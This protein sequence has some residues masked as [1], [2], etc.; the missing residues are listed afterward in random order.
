MN[1]LSSFCKHFAV[2]AAFMLSANF[3]QAQN[4]V[5]STHIDE[6]Y[7]YTTVVYKNTSASDND[8]LSSLNNDFSVGDVVR[9]TLAPPPAPIASSEPVYADKS[10]GEDAWLTASNSKSTASLTASASTNT[11]TKTPVNTIVA[12]PK[13]LSG[14]VKTASP[15]AVAVA[16]KPIAPKS[17][18]VPKAVSPTPAI[19]QKAEV[20]PKSVEQEMPKV[21]YAAGSKSGKVH[22][23]VKKSGKKGGK[24][25]KLKNR[26]HKKQRYSCPTF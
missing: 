12:A 15:K 14:S 16:T 23:S 9:V 26:K 21:K 24:K 5:E 1:S 10:K 18:E 4:P 6:K 7:A 17:N 3:L 19:E 2:P 20:A 22:K 11:A 25:M 8:V 13:A